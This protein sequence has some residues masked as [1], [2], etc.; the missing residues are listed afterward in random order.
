MYPV[1]QILKHTFSFD[2]FFDSCP[3]KRAIKITFNA[4]ELILASS[5]DK[6]GQAS[7]IKKQIIIR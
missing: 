1:S 7:N 5:P 2:C 6:S 3:M 4:S